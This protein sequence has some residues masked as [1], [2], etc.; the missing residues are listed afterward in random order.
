[1]CLIVIL[2][3]HPFDI[4]YSGRSYSGFFKLLPA[5]NRVDWSGTWKSE[6]SKLGKE[7][8]VAPI[9]FAFWGITSVVLT[10]TVTRWKVARD[11]NCDFQFSPAAARK[12]TQ[13]AT[14]NLNQRAELEDLRSQIFA[15]LNYNQSYLAGNRSRLS[16]YQAF[17]QF[18]KYMDSMEL[19]YAQPDGN[20]KYGLFDTLSELES[21]AMQR[22][23]HLVHQEL[24]PNPL[25]G[26]VG[27]VE[28][29]SGESIESSGRPGDDGVVDGPRARL[30][31]KKA[32]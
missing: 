23:A 32:D 5:L 10:F 8:S 26:R 19:D 21:A 31:K 2:V 4:D 25:I 12:S 22:F 27:T 17:K 6:F 9:A 29:S 16:T 1:M 13:A 15:Y 30:L 20:S 11:L 28:S 18:F 7:P 3:P 14:R 24:K